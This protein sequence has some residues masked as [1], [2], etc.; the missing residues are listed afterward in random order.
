MN[1]HQYT[2]VKYSSTSII[3]SKQL[4]KQSIQFLHEQLTHFFL[5]SNELLTVT[6]F[7]KRK[8]NPVG[9]VYYNMHIIQIQSSDWNFF[10]YSQTLFPSH[11]CINQ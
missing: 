9:S 3:I 10:S 7:K 1:V 2:A 4:G 6:F 5:S 8:Y 11:E